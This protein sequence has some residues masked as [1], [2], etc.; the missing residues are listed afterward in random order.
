LLE[1]IA[2]QVAPP[3]A[4]FFLPMK[5]VGLR[6]RFSPDQPLRQAVSVVI[7]PRRAAGRPRAPS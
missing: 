1:L 3:R 2:R 6:P 4:R 5:T 7:L